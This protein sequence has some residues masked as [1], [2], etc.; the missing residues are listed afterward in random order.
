MA[1]LRFNL[2]KAIEKSKPGLIIY[3]AGTDIFNEDELGGFS[4]TDAGIVR[5]D[6]F[7]FMQAL[8][9]KI[10]ILML[11]SGGYSQES[12]G[13]VS[14]SIENLLKRVLPGCKQ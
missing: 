9:R 2:P 6:E 1:L 7:V 3:N 14:R 12:A 13:I 4:I 11:L 10:P 5:R 8:N